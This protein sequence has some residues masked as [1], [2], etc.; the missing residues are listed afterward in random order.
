MKRRRGDYI[1]ISDKY[2]HGICTSNN[3]WN[4][5]NGAQ[6]GALY[7]Q[8]IIFLHLFTELFHKGISLLIRVNCSFL[9]HSTEGNDYA[10]Q[11]YNGIMQMVE[12]SAARSFIHTEFRKNSSIDFVM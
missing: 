1:S 6:Q 11:I 2:L 7:I 4:H 10:A 5:A 3:I 12:C 8:K 9:E